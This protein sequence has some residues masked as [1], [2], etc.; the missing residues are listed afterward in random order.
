M[1][2]ERHC[3]FGRHGPY[4]IINNEEYMYEAKVSPKCEDRIY[5]V[6]RFTVI[7][8]CERCGFV[9]FVSNTD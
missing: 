6:K 4:K 7:L 8:Q 5:K 9:K 1:P 3:R 2:T